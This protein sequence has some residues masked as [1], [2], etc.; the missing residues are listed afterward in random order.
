LLLKFSTLVLSFSNKKCPAHISFT[1]TSLTLLTAEQA[2]QFGCQLPT[3]AFHLYIWRQPPYSK[4]N[5]NH[6]DKKTSPRRIL[7]ALGFPAH[8]PGR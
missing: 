2:G 6:F 4:T 8:T 5:S 1:D 7:S 3:S